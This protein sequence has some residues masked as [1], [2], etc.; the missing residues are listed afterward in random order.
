M[1]TIGY[2]MTSSMR[3]LDS[4]TL[5]GMK[6]IKASWYSMALYIRIGIICQ[7]EQPRRQDEMN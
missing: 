3:Y 4:E 5:E 7:E 1:V 2:F 6:A